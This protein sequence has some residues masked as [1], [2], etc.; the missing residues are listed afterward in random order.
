MQPNWEACSRIGVLEISLTPMTEP[1]YKTAKA[2]YYFRL[3][4]I[5]K[6]TTDD[7]ALLR[8]ASLEPAFKIELTQDLQKLETEKIEIEKALKALAKT[9]RAVKGISKFLI[10]IRAG[11]GGE[12]AALFAA[13]LWRMYTR[14]AERQGWPVT[15]FDLNETSLYGIKEVIFGI[16]APG[17]YRKLGFESGTHRV[18]R[19]PA[20]EKNGRVHTSTV[21]VAVLPE[22]DDIE[23][24]INP[25]DLRV[26]TYRSSGKGGQH[27]NRTDSA[28][29]LVHL[30]TGLMVACQ[31]ERSQ[32]KNREVAMRLLKTKL[33]ELEY[34]SQVGS[35][36][37]QRRALIGEAKRSEKIRTYNFPQDRLT[38]HRVQVNW[39]NLP[40]LLDGDIDEMLNDVSK[41]LTQAD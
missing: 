29:R 13:E 3:Q 10:E 40:K 2:Q 36:R 24:E 23:I 25:D 33:F 37:S 8:E 19:I 6:E 14:Y 9:E 31:N 27:V 22:P 4:T 34:E 1:D 17:A 15:L 21:S 7:Q 39:H 16:E 26:D 5:Q 28:I 18:Q 30:P 20:T 12:E 41:K 32:H 38:D 35:E 11:T